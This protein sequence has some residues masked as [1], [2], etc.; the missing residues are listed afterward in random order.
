M[1]E[2]VKVAVLRGNQATRL[3]TIG[4]HLGRWALGAW[5]RRRASLLEYPFFV[6]PAEN[7]AGF[8]LRIEPPAASCPIGL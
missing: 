6:C 5:P 8:L 3:T 7:R 2:K 4:P 1:S